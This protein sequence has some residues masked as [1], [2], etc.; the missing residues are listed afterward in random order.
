MMKAFMTTLFAVLTIGS[1]GLATTSALACHGGSGGYGGYSSHYY[2]EYVQRVYVQE[3]VIVAPTFAPSHSLVFVIP[4]DSWF[5]ICSREYGNTSV[6]S[7]VADFNS[8]PQNLQL[9]S[10]MQLRLPV[11]NQNGTFSLSSAPAAAAV[12]PQAFAGGFQQ[13]LP[14]GP[15]QG[16][17]QGAQRGPQSGLPQANGF[18]QQG[19]GFAPPQLPMG[20]PQGGQPGPSYGVTMADNRPVPQSAPPTGAGQYG[21]QKTC[22]VTDEKLGKMGTP[23]PVTIKGQ[24]IYVCCQGCVETVQSDPDVYLTKAARERSGQ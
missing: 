7:K 14:Q 18:V 24:T 12:A 1:V 17:P 4:G 21:G 5:S 10:G 2:P 6:W 20:Q 8:M 13:G 3:R 11:I 23:V 16:L 9:T 19:Q 15:P 22:P